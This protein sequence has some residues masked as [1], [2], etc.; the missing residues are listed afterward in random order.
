MLPRILATTPRVLARVGRLVGSDVTAIA[1]AGRAVL[2]E[3]Q[4]RQQRARVAPGARSEDPG[5]HLDSIDSERCWQLLAT[6]PFGRLSFT[7][8][9]GVP[10]IVPVNFAVDGKTL[11]LR[12]GRGPKLDAA[13]RGDFV[14]F[15][16]DEIDVANR[17]GWSVVV[18]GQAGLATGAAERRRLSGIGLDPWVTGPRDAYVVI[19]P[20]N[21]AGR[22]LHGDDE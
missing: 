21:I 5:Q 13:T 9:S 14:A 12:S 1:N 4:D 17:T 7:A 2:R 3:E 15:E 6:Q 10:V 8:H 19:T 22:W 18:I 16:A 20:R 11:V